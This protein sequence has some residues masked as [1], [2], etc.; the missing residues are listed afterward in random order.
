[1]PNAIFNFLKDQDQL[2]AGVSLN[3]RSNASFGTILGGVLSVITT[4]FFTAFTGLCI[5]TWAFLP[6]FNQTFTQSYLQRKSDT[7]YTVPMQIFLPTVSVYS[8][9]EDG[10]VYVNNSTY[11]TFYWS[12][13]ANF[14]S[15]E[16]LPVSCF[17]LIDSWDISYEEKSAIAIEIL[18]EA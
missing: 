5:Y 18:D 15:T 17:D 4:L 2:G 14:T 7:I 10:E 6:Q 16:V 8:F 12:V 1:M 13:N 3:Y 11:F 9:A